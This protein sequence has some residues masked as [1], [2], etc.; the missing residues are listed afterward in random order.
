MA[1]HFPFGVKVYLRL[2]VPS[3]SL[4][5]LVPSTQTASAQNLAQPMARLISSTPKA[6]GFPGPRR[7]NVPADSAS[8]KNL[9]TDAA[10]TVAP[11][12]DDATLT[13]RR[14]F[15]VTNAVRERNGLA[16]LTWEADL[17]R[18]ARAHSRNMG[19]LEFFS[20][21][22]PEGFRLRDRARASGILRFK[23][24]A[25]NIAYNQGHEDPG[26]FAVERWMISPGHRANILSREFQASAIGS[27]VANDG[28]VYL[29][30][31]FLAR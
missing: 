2:I 19:T 24:L 29:T 14:V 10:P 20:H 22:G 18:M 28:R 27:F 5:F 13:E 3:L 31:V 4:I 16:P 11:S 30:Q 8:A 6:T 26:A 21:E 23:V 17:C 1:F 7:V 15:D 25:E 12:I 9:S